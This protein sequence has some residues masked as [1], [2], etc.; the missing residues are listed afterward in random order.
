MSAFQIVALM[1]ATVMVAVIL[2]GMF[3]QRRGK[4][5]LFSLIVVWLTAVAAILVPEATMSAAATVG[6]G[7]GADLLLYVA[8]LAGLVALFAI[9]LR[10]AALESQITEL[11]RHVA[12]T[13]VRRSQPNDSDSG[14]E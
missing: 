13:E 4:P 3:R 14:Q 10:F 5:V 11:V 7:R 1:L 2:A 9:Y 12:I 6:I 8:V